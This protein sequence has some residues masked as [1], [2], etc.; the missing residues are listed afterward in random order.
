M[1]AGCASFSSDAQC[2]LP[3]TTPGRSPK[4]ALR[5]VTYA[6]R[7]DFYDRSLS[8]AGVRALLAQLRSVRGGTGSVALTAL[9]GAVSR[10]RPHGRRGRS[11]AVPGSS[12]QYPVSWRPGPGGTARCWLAEARR[13]MRRAIASGAACQRYTDPALA[14]WRPAYSWQTLAPE[15]TQREETVRPGPGLHLPAGPL[16]GRPRAPSGRPLRGQVPR[17]WP[18]SADPPLGAARPGRFPASR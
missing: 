5:R 16:T 13:A 7:S 18:A 11:A 14:D 1:Y 15:L 8:A 6:A 17:P 9:G 10:G 3:G 2:H 12:H 4:G